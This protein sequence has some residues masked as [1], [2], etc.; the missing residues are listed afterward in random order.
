[1]QNFAR[2]AKTAGQKAV[3]VVV[4]GAASSSVA[5]ADAPREE[6]VSSSRH[7]IHVRIMLYLAAYWISNWACCRAAACEGDGP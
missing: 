6:V 5:L 7:R 2:F 4:A 1:M 3:P